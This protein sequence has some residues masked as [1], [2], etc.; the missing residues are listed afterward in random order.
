M[1]TRRTRR[2]AI[3]FCVFSAL[4]LTA[5]G[6]WLAGPDPRVE[7][8]FDEEVGEQR[9][10]AA[11]AV[12]EAIDLPEG[13]QVVDT[14]DEGLQFPTIANQSN[15]RPGGIRIQL[16]RPDDKSQAIWVNDLEAA[17]LATGKVEPYIRRGSRTDSC[18]GTTRVHFRHKDTGDQFSIIYVP[19]A[20]APL[21]LWYQV[22]ARIE[23]GSFGR[24][25][26]L[27]PHPTPYCQ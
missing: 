22:S 26:D 27:E 8:L 4:F 24:S 13:F 3:L 10:T 11:I 5:C 20:T 2:V 18:E 16:K 12:L 1:R 25:R 9:R 15:P 7:A 21:T 14:T 19:A 6:G 17:I 23:F